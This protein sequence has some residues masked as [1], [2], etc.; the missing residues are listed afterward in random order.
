MT[1][2]LVSVITP[3]RRGGEEL[4]RCIASVQAQGYHH[5]E[6]VIVMDEG[7]QGYL[8]GTRQGFAVD[9]RYLELN[10]LWRTPTTTRST[11]AYPWLIGTQFARGEYITFLGDDDEMLPRHCEAHVEAMQ[12]TGADY[13]LS[14]VDFYVDGE[15]ALTIGDGRVAITHLDSDSIACRRET[16]RVANWQANGG[17]S[18]DFEM[19][20][21]WHN[22]GLK[23][24]FVDEVT[25]RHN[26]GW[27]STPEM[28]PILEAARR[29]EDWRKLMVV[30]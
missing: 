10:D 7:G 30:G 16:L 26:D 11:G 22:A 29:Q 2:G 15:Y 1:P 19:A 8:P 12:E 3:S 6:H 28:R 25:C 27:L 13:S 20:L 18:P 9:V 17:N 21:R 23:G 4:K 24:C 14:K 5:V